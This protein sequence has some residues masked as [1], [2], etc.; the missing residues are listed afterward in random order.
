MAKSKAY[1]GCDSFMLN[2]QLVLIVAG[3]YARNEQSVEF[4][5]PN[6]EVPRWRPGKIF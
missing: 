3:S 4:L 5:L 1:S 2:N 6:E